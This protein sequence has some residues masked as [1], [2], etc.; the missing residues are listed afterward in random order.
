MRCCDGIRYAGPLEA[1]RDDR[2]VLPVTS[3]VES[4]NGKKHF[5]PL[6]GDAHPNVN[7]VWRYLIPT[8]H[9]FPTLTNMVCSAGI[10][11]LVN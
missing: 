8:M 7:G 1:M 10:N 3:L 2:E 11:C 9:C 6:F 5:L 4:H